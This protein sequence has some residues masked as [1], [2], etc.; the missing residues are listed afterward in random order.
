M[1][2]QALLRRGLLEP[3]DARAWLAGQTDEVAP[4]PNLG[5]AAELVARHVQAGSRIVVHG[6]YDVDGVCATAILLDTLQFL[7]R[8]RAGTCPSAVLTATASRP[9]ASSA[10]PAWGRSS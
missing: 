5:A 1:T 7:G 6:D 9:R 2:G 3:A 4:L 10:S 8:R